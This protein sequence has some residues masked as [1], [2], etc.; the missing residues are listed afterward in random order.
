MHHILCELKEIF[1]FFFFFLFKKIKNFIFL[2]LLEFVRTIKTNTIFAI[3]DLEFTESL[4][5]NQG[6]KLPPPSPPS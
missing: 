2:L 5:K 6:E 3:Y 1:F 4:E